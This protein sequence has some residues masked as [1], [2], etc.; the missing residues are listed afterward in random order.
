MTVTPRAI[1]AIRVAM[2]SLLTILMVRIAWLSDD[3][4]ITLRTALNLT[5]G[6]G[7][8]FNVTEAVQGYTHPLWFLLWSAIGSVTNQWI[9]GILALG[10]GLSLAA[11]GLVLWRTSSIPVILAATG[12]L[13]MSNAFMDYTSSGLENP[14]S[15]ALV[16]ILMVLTLRSER[17]TAASV[18]V[19]LTAAAV[20]LTRLDL[21]LL[22]I[23]ALI[24]WVWQRRTSL[25]NLGI[26]IASGVIPLIVWFGWSWLTYG[27]L[28][29][30]TFEAKRNL[31]IPASELVS[32]GIAYLWVSFTHDPITFIVILGAMLAAIVGDSP[33]ARPWA[34]GIAVYMAYVVWIGGDFMAFRFLAVPCYVAVFILVVAVDAFAAR[35]R[36]RRMEVTPASLATVGALLLV[37]LGGSA[38]LG[39]V[40]G[41]LAPVTAPRF[42]EFNIA[43]ERGNYYP[44]RDFLTMVRSTLNKFEEA[45][46]QGYLYQLNVAAATWPD[47][48]PGALPPITA[49]IPTYCVFAGNAL[50]DGPLVHHIDPCGLTDRYLA[51]V[52]Y[53]PE[54]PFLWRMG[55]FPRPMPDGYWEAVVTGDTSLVKDP[56]ERER[57]IALWERIRA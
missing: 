1:L 45:P 18:L 23:P 17:S 36:A 50:E 41:A 4:I 37:L 14:L 38:A 12:L 42:Y 24:V 6:W 11:V 5:H 16:G 47:R 21:V 20:A 39:A 49:P 40:P 48:G 3:A 19:G 28:L 55:H 43:D 44:G 33:F 26:A 25:R 32:Q 46:K 53:E 35:E 7:P 54:K 13:A 31:A 8:G 27:S 51:E 22:V 34:L 56:A 30:N 29:P 9:L 57:L 52:T 2:L 15:Y 10:V